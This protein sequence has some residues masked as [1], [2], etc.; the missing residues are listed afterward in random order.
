MCN[1]VQSLE[2]V[3]I[4][5]RCFNILHTHT[6]IGGNLPLQREDKIKN[7]L[8]HAPTH[9]CM[10]IHMHARWHTPTPTQLFDHPV[11]IA[12]QGEDNQ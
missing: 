5:M 11:I 12:A 4:Q 6:G 10:H 1:K 9:T 3:Q 7:S 2:G 8:T